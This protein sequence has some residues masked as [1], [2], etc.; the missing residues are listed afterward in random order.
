MAPITGT[1][2]SSDV[3]SRRENAV[4][5]LTV[6]AAKFRVR[7]AR[8]QWA[9]FPTMTD[10]STFAVVLDLLEE[11]P[12]EDPLLRGDGTVTERQRHTAVRR[13]R[14]NAEAQL[15]LFLLAWEMK[16]EGVGSDDRLA[17]ELLDFATTAYERFGVNLLRTAV[18]H[19][20][21][22]PADVPDVLLSE[23]SVEAVENGN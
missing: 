15:T 4:D 5:F 8:L 12:G 1:P 22:L 16:S 17:G 20:D 9:W 11:A 2:T 21:E 3:F 23:A 18:E 7:T 6:Y 19:R 13:V 14:G 10:Q